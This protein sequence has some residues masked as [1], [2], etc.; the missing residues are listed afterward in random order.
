MRAT[1]HKMLDRLNDQLD[2]IDKIIE[3]LEEK[4]VESQ[5]CDAVN[6]LDGM[7]RGPCA[8]KRYKI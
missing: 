6:K 8:G 1:H 4:I 5:I 3:F 7:F 2:S